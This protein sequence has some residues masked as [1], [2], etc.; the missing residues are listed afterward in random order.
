MLT[1]RDES[2]LSLFLANDKHIRYAFELVVA[3]LSSYL[4]VPVVHDDAYVL[5]LELFLHLPCIIVRFLGDGQYHYLVRSEPEWELTGGMLDEHSHETLHRTERSTVDH[6]RTVLLV[7]LTHILQ[8]ETLWQVVVNLD[9]T[10]LPTATQCVLNHEVEL[11]TIE[12]GLT[13]L[14]MSVHTFL[15]ACLD[16]CVLCL[17]PYLVRT[18]ILV[19]VVLVAK[20]DL[21]LEILEVKS[22]EDDLNDLHHF[23][24]LFF[25]LVGTAE[26]MCV[27]LSERAHT[28]Q[29]VQLARLLVAI[30]RTELSTTERQVFV[31]TR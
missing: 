2:F 10:E 17:L 13:I 30:N 5:C 25:H 18:H 16:D 11:R 22:A 8:L 28:S 14:N 31:R 29:S 9:G 1:N 24:E 21:S 3:Y 20:R 7:V 19:V 12:S 27:V 4:L 15:T 6:D 23:D 26:D